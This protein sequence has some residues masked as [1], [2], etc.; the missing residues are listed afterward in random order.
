MT[1]PDASIWGVYDPPEGWRY[2]FPKLYR[3]LEGESL[4]DTLIRDGY[5]A[6]KI[7]D[8]IHVRFLATQEVP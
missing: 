8:E 5:P 3:P 4:R 2:G 7:S 6:D 1:L